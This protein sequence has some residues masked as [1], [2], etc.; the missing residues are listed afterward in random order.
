MYPHR[1]RLRGPWECVPL[2]RAADDARPLPPQ[3]RMAMPCRW[4]AGG[5]SE[6]SGRIR[7]QRNFGY[8]G[9]ID[10]HERVWLTVGPASDR[11]RITL[12]G[13]FL[14]ER[15]GGGCEFEVTA[16]LR[17]RNELAVEVEG[18]ATGGL[19]GEV[20][21]EV[22]CSAFLQNLQCGAMVD[23][24]GSAQIHATGELAG[25]AADELELYLLLDRSTVAYVALPAPVSGQAFHLVSETLP[26]QRWHASAGR[27]PPHRVQIDLVRA[28]TVWYTWE[29]EL[30]LEPPTGRGD[31]KDAW[32][33]SR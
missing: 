23:G 26:S 30:T 2:A 16:L 18:V 11:V 19:W 17:D 10:A 32:K 8:P 5:L 33:S 25:T 14:G 4:A 22:R 13:A 7:F 24:S 3:R 20:A 29:Q 9:R 31:E 12:N 21:L 1:I 6:F 28:A 27:G 15:E